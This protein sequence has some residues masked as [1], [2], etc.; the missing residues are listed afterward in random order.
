M[1][2]EARGLQDKRQRLSRY[3]AFATELGKDTPA[4]FL[5]SP[6]FIYLL[7]NAVKGVSITDITIPS[8]RFMTI[9]DWYIDTEKVWTFL[10][11]H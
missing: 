8:D 9:E 1:L 6:E 4:I 7:P 11:T 10:T 3:D 5:Y 2:T